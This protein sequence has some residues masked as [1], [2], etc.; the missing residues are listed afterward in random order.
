MVESYYN[1]KN[2]CKKWHD[3]FTCPHDDCHISK[4][5]KKS[6]G[7]NTVRIE[8]N[9]RIKELLHKGYNTDQVSRMIGISVRQ[10]QAIRNI[11]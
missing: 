5:E 7:G 6:N 9:K 1:V 8:R 11:N 3:C 2:G 4:K 10:V